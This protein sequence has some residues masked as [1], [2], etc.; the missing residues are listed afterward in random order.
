MI[1][2]KRLRKIF[3]TDICLKNNEIPMDFF[4]KVAIMPTPGPMKVHFYCEVALF[5]QEFD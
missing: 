5:N 2:R 1:F 3:S 4:L